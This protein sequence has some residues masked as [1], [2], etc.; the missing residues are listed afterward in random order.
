MITS[1][2]IEY[3]KGELNDNVSKDLIISTLLE[4]GWRKED[5][6]EGFSSIDINTEPKKNIDKYREIPEE[7]NPSL[8]EAKIEEKN[9]PVINKPV[10]TTFYNV[11]PIINKPIIATPVINPIKLEPKL[12]LVT[13]PKVETKLEIKPAFAQSFGEAK[14]EQVIGEELMPIINKPVIETPV[15]IPEPKPIFAHTLAVEGTGY[16]NLVIETKEE[17][18]KQEPVK[19]WTPTTIKP[20]IN[21]IKIGNKEPI[22]NIMSS[23]QD[24]VGD[25]IEEKKETFKEVIPTIN[26]ISSP[27]IS[28]NPISSMSDIVPKNAMISSYMGD[29][30][31]VINKE[32]TEIVSIHRK[33]RNLK[34]G[35]IITIVI[36]IAIMVFAFVAGYIKIPGSK[37]SLFVVKKDPKVILLNS[38]VSISKLKSFKTQTNI[39]ISS[40]V[41]SNITTGLSSGDVVTSKDKDYISINAKGLINHEDNKSIFDYMFDFKSSLLKKDINTNLKY[42]GSNVYIDIPDLKN[43]FGDNMPNPVKLYTERSKLD[44]IIKELPISTQ[45][46]F[47]KFDIY[48]IISMETPLYVE[49][50]T[51]RIIE[52]FINTFEYVDK[53]EEVLYGVD[54]I[55]YQVTVT[56]AATKKVL[57]SLADLFVPQLSPTEKQDLDEAIGA[58]SISSFDIWT[59]KNDDNLYQIKFSLSAPLSKILRLND[60]GIAGNEVVLDWDTSFYDLDVANNISVPTGEID[61]DGFIKNIQDIKIKNQ[62][63]SFKEQALLFKNAVGSYGKTPNTTGSCTAPISGSMF[64]P[65]GHSKGADTAVSSISDT[66]N[67]LLTVTKNEGYCYSTSKAWALS[68]PLAGTPNSYYCSDSK[69][70][71]TTISSPIIE[72]S[73]LV[74]STPTL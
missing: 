3:I 33:K 67:S 24:V 27:I 57:T 16:N 73:C 34:L 1:D 36:L 46:L 22:A 20:V 37:S 41:L 58:T 23:K 40:P 18:I 45:N 53:G 13:E 63:S 52:E 43:I 5:I 59:G 62:V 56:R 38:S 28:Q 49:N 66:M 47:K 65:L 31:T 9:T 60:S 61:I 32:D 21:E 17:T 68:V 69:G 26:K 6:D 7:G 4:I 29:V 15:S 12:E 55:H 50:E 44:L 72:T 42:D 39:N 74:K 30:S 70:E 11:S 8:L 51:A 48:N 19:A 14:P 10:D 2:L 54:T 71:I 25:T 35:I 64:S